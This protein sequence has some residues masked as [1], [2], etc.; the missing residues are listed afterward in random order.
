MSTIRQ[1]IIT[2]LKDQ[3]FS[4]RELSPIIGIREKEVYEHLAHIARS[5]A[6]KGKLKIQPAVCRDCGFEF[7]KR[8][9]L[10]PP[11]RCFHCRSESIIPPKFLI[12]E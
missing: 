6:V 12:R 11:G 2:L 9:R 4:A 5:A 8:E 3:E 7:R 1:A 10:T